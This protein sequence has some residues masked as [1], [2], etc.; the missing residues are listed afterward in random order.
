M[1]RDLH[2]KAAVKI[3]MTTTSGVILIQKDLVLNHGLFS[4]VID[5]GF[6]LEMKKLE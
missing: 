1:E 6:L 3:R 2:S 4:K 5:S